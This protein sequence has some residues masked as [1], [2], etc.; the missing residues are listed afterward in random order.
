M[1]TWHFSYKINYG[2]LQKKKKKIYGRRR[3]KRGNVWE[4]FGPYFLGLPLF[5]F[6]GIAGTA[7]LDGSCG[8]VVECGGADPGDALGFL[9]HITHP[10]HTYHRVMVSLE[11]KNI[12]INGSVDKKKKGWRDGKNQTSSRAKI[13]VMPIQM[14][15]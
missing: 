4:S 12:K 5:F 14:R 3:C 6:T 2:R 11:E 15:L 9:A 13:I 7:T 1:L 10:N 8:G